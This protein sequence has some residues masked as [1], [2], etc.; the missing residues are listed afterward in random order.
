M[1]FTEPAVMVLQI[2]EDRWSDKRSSVSNTLLQIVF[3]S[4]RQICS[5]GFNSG[6]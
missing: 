2:A 3:L 6:L 1:D 4:I 5:A